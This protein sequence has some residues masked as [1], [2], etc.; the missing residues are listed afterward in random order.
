MGI[1]NSVAA[2]INRNGNS[3]IIHNGD[4]QIATRAFVEPLR[5]KNRIYIG[6][7]K[8]VLGMYNS[9]KYLF[10][11]KPA[12]SVFEDKSIVECG[13]DKF[14]VKRKEIYRVSNEPVYTWA[15]MTRYQERTED[16]YDSDKTAFGYDY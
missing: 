16:E 6:G 1:F 5:Y 7:R 2:M 3:V 12:D 4:S 10:I 11:G 13:G 8:H 14:I 9:E 15:I